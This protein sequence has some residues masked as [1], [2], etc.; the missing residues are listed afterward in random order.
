ML[1]S[2]C[3][4]MYLHIHLHDASVIFCLAQVDSVS[5][6][7][8]TISHILGHFLHSNAWKQVEQEIMSSHGKFAGD[9]WTSLDD[10]WMLEIQP[11]DVWLWDPASET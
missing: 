4:Y 10:H 11:L 5:Q 6:A 1:Y 3:I 2:Y 8:H 9:H 7:S